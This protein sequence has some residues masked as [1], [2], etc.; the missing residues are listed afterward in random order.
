MNIGDRIKRLRGKESQASFSKHVGI[1]KNTLGRYER[2]EIFP[3]GEAIAQLCTSLNIDANW[4]VLGKDGDSKNFTKPPVPLSGGE[5]PHAENA[6]QAFIQEAMSALDL[7]AQED[8]AAYVLE[9]TPQGLYKQRQTGRVPKKWK[10]ALAKKIDEKL[11]KGR[12]FSTQKEISELEKELRTEKKER[13]VLAQEVLE[14][15]A[16]NRR[17]WKEN[18]ELRVDLAK[19]QA[20]DTPEDVSTEAARRSA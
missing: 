20:R 2:N 1:P 11:N 4:L 13:R 12:E 6:V 15:N 10:A 9:I 14:L 7:P 8:V 17:L 19:R 5:D 3:G 16:E 18:A